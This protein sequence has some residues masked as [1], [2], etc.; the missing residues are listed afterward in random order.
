MAN[1]NTNET[2]QV[3]KKDIKKMNKPENT[4]QNG[5]VYSKEGGKTAF[6]Q[7][8]KV[9]IKELD[10]KPLGVILSGILKQLEIADK[11]YETQK[12][13]NKKLK[14][15]IVELERKAKAYGME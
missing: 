12:K 6:R 9:T 1:T 5:M 8:S 14:E 10:K 4:R 15:R 7:L 3:D 2:V 11:R 13:I